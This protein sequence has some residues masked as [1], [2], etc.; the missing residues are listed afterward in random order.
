MAR[1]GE[2]RPVEGEERLRHGV[3]AESIAFF[4]HHADGLAPD[5]DDVGFGHGRS[6]GYAEMVPIRHF[7]KHNGCRSLPFWKLKHLVRHQCGDA[8][9]FD[10]T[11]RHDQAMNVAQLRNVMSAKTCLEH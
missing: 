10:E 5:F 11:N 2:L 4:R 7:D 6:P 1:L 3:K 8:I 9:I